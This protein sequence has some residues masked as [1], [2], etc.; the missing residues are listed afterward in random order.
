MTTVRLN[1]TLPSNIALQLDEMV[2]PKMK[3]R[4]IAEA[5]Q[6]RLKQIQD[7]RLNR[8]LAEGY[9]DAC[10]ESIDMAGEFEIVDME[11]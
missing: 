2:G 9:K 7:E 1:I 3:S 10:Q 5:I 11:G 8:A 4:F 6:E